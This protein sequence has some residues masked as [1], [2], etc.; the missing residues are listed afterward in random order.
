VQQDDPD[1]AAGFADVR[2]QMTVAGSRVVLWNANEDV[3]Q[4]EPA[5]L[6]LFLRDRTFARDAVLV[7][8]ERVGQR[9]A[10][11]LLYVRSVRR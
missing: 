11:E 5:P 2:A 6:A 3:T 7:V 9:L 4:P 1:L 8:L 10:N